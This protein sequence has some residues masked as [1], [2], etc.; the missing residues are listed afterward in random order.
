MNPV[1]IKITTATPKIIMAAALAKMAFDDTTIQPVINNDFKCDILITF[2]T[3]DF[4]DYAKSDRKPM[5]RMAS[6]IT[7]SIVGLVWKHYGLQILD[8]LGCI[9]EYQE[10][11]WRRV[12]EKY[13]SVFDSCD[14]ETFELADCPTPSLD[15]T[16]DEI[17][18]FMEQQICAQIELLSSCICEGILE[19]GTER[20]IQSLIAS[21]GNKPYIELESGTL[22]WRK[23]VDEYNR[24]NQEG[25]P[26]KFVIYPYGKEFVAESVYTHPLQNGHEEHIMQFATDKTALI[27]E[28]R[29]KTK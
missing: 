9:S 16:E 15:A 25:M 2:K 4:K 7:L 21:K 28:F 8:K 18:S 12:D 29:R 26:I 24:F 14:S 17:I 11:V 6:S 1:N 22:P 27:K 10:I 20:Y 23:K 13:I 5:L 19:Y 3:L